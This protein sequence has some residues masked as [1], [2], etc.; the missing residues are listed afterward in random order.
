M[1]VAIESMTDEERDLK[2]RIDS[3]NYQPLLNSEESLCYE[4][5]DDDKDKRIINDYY[6]YNYYHCYD[7]IC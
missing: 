7:M 4:I 2:G 3:K 5:L 1:I 6:N